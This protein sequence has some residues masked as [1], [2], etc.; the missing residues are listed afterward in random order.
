MAAT[1]ALAQQA[2]PADTTTTPEP[3]DVII[4]TGSLSKNPATATA[5]PV[6]TV[7]AENLSDRGITS[8]SE[9]LQLTPA[10]P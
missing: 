3:K 4:V 9:A 8:V 7:T 5:S 1:P 10:V 2:V 6:V